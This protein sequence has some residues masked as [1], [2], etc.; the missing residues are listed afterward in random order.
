MKSLIL[1]LEKNLF[2][3]EYMSNIEWMNKTI[4]DNFVECGKS[5]K[6]FHKKDT[7]EELSKLNEDRKIDI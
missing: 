3:K 4:S 5:G 2:K 1:E 7:I 6:F